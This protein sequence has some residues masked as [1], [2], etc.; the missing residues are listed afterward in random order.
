MIWVPALPDRI[1]NVILQETVKDKIYDNGAVYYFK[2]L[3][4]F[5]NKNSLMLS[6]TST[7][8]KSKYLYSSIAPQYYN[9]NAFYCPNKHVKQDLVKRS[10]P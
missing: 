10:S 1:S 7:S 8:A 4:T 6:H 5:N 3:T 9:C 2:I